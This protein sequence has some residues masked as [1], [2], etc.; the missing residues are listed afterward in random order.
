LDF[1]RR[2]TL[3]VR[4]FGEDP[5]NFNSKTRLGVVLQKVAIPKNLKVK[6]LIDLLRS[7][8]PNALS[9]GEILNTVNLKGKENNWASKLSGGEAQ[10]LF[11]ALALVGNPEF[12]ILDEPTRNLD[13]EGLKAFLNF[14]SKLRFVVIEILQF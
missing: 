11:F 4:L 9:T 10:R 6:E 5:K 7:Y 8:Y 2:S 13:E 14:G 1:F 3:L 12:L